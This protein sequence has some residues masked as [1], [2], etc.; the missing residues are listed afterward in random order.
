M[1]QRIIDWLLKRSQALRGASAPAEST[2]TSYA[3]YQN[4]ILAGG[5]Q[6]RLLFRVSYEQPTDC[7]VTLGIAPGT[8]QPIDALF[9]RLSAIPA[10]VG[11]PHDP[12]YESSVGA[13]WVEWLCGGA[14]QSAL[15]DLGAGALSLPAVDQVTVK[16]ITFFS[17]APPAEGRFVC[18][19]LPTRSPGATAT[20]TRTPV[21]VDGFP[22][23]SL[24][25]S[26]WARRW[27]ATISDGQSALLPPIAVGP[28]VVDVIDDP[29][30]ASLTG[31]QVTFGGSLAGIG[32]D[33]AQ[34]GW[35]ETGGFA[36]SYVMHNLG[37][38]PATVK[39]V[40][41]IQVG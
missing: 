38:A 5:T 23:A 10:N 28:V 15:V 40:E 9:P 24:F 20:C 18:Q 11:S 22:V 39:I 2:C 8:G 29:G 6:A 14:V 7:T 36:L 27:K 37:A 35:I 31:E 30:G 34:Q 17:L 4:A 32:A 12:S 1:S 21:I 16:F 25:R 13:Y 41:Q 3:Q 19:V 26:Q 33:A